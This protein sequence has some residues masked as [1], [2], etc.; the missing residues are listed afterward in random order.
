MARVLE[1]IWVRGNKYFSENPKKK[2]RQPCQQT[3]RRANHSIAP[4]DL[5]SGHVAPK[6]RSRFGDQNLARALR[7]SLPDLIRQSIF[8]RRLMDTRV[9]LREDALRAFARV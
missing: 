7:A 2:T 4:F 3:A 5:S 6:C 1:L 8:S 9:I